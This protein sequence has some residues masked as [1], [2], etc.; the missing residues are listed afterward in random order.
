MDSKGA[1]VQ[2]GTHSEVTVNRARGGWKQECEGWNLSDW[3]TYR[4]FEG[5]LERQRSRIAK[6]FK[7]FPL[8][9]S[10][11]RVMFPQLLIHH[12]YITTQHVGVFSSGCFIFINLHSKCIIFCRVQVMSFTA[13]NNLPFQRT[14]TKG[15]KT[16]VLKPAQEAPP[17]WPGH[18]RDVER[19]ML[20]HHGSALP[21]VRKS[22][23]KHHLKV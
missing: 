18:P 12:A 23:Y 6:T 1:G 4:I 2:A 21:V 20:W 7:G 9:W 10:Y 5:Q 13:Q 22:T 19:W 3:E 15:R 11:S 8:F 16:I 17:K 14:L